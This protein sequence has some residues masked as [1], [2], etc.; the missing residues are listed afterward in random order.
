MTIMGDVFR[1]LFG[2]FVADL[3]LTLSVLGGV[4]L[5]AILM[6]SAVLGPVAAGFVLALGCVLILVETVLR[7][8]RRGK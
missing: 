4:L 8:T 5:V 2:M 3:R 1:E 6:N 7:E